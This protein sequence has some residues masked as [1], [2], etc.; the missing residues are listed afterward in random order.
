MRRIDSMLR[1]QR[2]DRRP[3]EEEADARSEAE[4]VLK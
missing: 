3:K 2:G 4:Q 1:K